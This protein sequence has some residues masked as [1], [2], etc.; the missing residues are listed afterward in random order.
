MHAPLAGADAPSVTSPPRP[1]LTYH[2]LEKLPVPR[3]VDRIAYVKQRCRDLRVLDLGAYDETEVGK[4][5]HG[6]WTW[7][8]AEIAAI[9][10]P[11]RVRSMASH[12]GN[13]CALARSAESAM[14]V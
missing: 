6:S 3:P 7:L 13:N 8:H 5:Q 9:P 14:R 1:S 12:R 2:P 11:T 10:S 4:P